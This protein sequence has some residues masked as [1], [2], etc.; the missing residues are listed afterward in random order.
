[1][2]ETQHTKE[3]AEGINPQHLIFSSLLITCCNNR[4][5]IQ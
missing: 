4:F 5:N 2:R 3:D 1:M